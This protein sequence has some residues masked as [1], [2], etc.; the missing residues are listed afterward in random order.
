M[1][2][3]V[4]SNILCMIFDAFGVLFFSSSKSIS[5]GDGMRS[6]TVTIQEIRQKVSE[7]NKNNNDNNSNDNNDHYNSDSNTD[8]V[9]MIVIIMV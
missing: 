2:G 8:I 4:C 5:T 6:R 9:I 1:N 3:Y 7:A